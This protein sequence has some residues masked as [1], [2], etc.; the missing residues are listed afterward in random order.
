MCP[1]FCIC[2]Y[3]ATTMYTSSQAAYHDLYWTIGDGGPQNDPYDNGQDPGQFHGSLVR[4]SVP[5][6]AGIVGYEIP[7]GNAFDGSAGGYRFTGC[8]GY[9]MSGHW[10][11]SS[12]NWTCRSGNWMRRSNHCMSWS[13]LWDGSFQ[14][15]KCCTFVF[16]GAL[17][18]AADSYVLYFVQ[19]T[20]PLFRPNDCT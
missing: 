15:L 11:R 8:T 7:T 20:L 3:A 12:N 6:T 16:H 18:I 1:I 9:V 14:S 4:I 2:L 19:E 10:I 13:G 5:S 17:A